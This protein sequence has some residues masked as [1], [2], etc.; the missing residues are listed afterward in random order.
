MAAVAL[1]RAAVARDPG[2]VRREVGEGRGGS[3][4]QLLPLASL[5]L[6]RQT[7]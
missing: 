1:G 7:M 6:L 2:K 5:H 3:L 4:G